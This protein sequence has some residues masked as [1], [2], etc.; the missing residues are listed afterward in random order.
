VQSQDRK[1]RSTGGIYFRFLFAYDKILLRKVAVV[2]PYWKSALEAGFASFASI[3]AWVSRAL[4]HEQPCVA[5]H[6]ADLL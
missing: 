6:G 4:V 5:A 3:V 2:N 1:R